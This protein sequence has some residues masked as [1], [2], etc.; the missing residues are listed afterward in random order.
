LDVAAMR[1][2]PA[3]LSV[4]LLGWGCGGDRATD[5]DAAFCREA[6]ERV[7]AFLGPEGDPLRGEWASRGPGGDG[8]GPLPDL[9]PERYGGTAVVGSTQELR[10][11]LNG[12]MGSHYRSVQHQLHLGLMTLVRRRGGDLE[13]EEYLARDWALA[14][15]GGAVTFHLRDDVR[16]HDGVPVTARDVA[17]TFDRL[18]DPAT[19]APLGDQWEGYRRGPDGVTVGDSLTLTFH[20]DPRSEPL[21]PWLD[22][23]IMPEHLLGEVPAEG[24]LGHPLGTRCPVG[25]GPFVFVEHRQDDRWVFR[26]NP[27]FPP[28]LGGRPFLDRYVYRVVPEQ[29]TLL[30]ELL[31]GGIDVF[32]RPVPEYAGA[33]EAEPGVRLLSS[34][35]RSVIYIAWNTRRP[36]LS[37]PRVRR[38]FTLGLDRVLYLQ[39]MRDGR[40]VLAGSGVPPFHWAYDPRL[41][42]LLRPDPERARA[43]LEEAGWSLPP[44]GEIRSDAEGNPLRITLL[45]DGRSVE[46]SDIALF[47]QAGLR[48]LGVEVRLQPLEFGTLLSRLESAQRDFDATVMSTLPPFRVDDR[49]LFHS[50]QRESAYGWAGLADPELDRLLD[51]LP[52]VVDRG[53]AR[54]LW[55]AYQRR[56]VE[57]QPYTYLFFPDWL[58]AVR[59]RLR[60]VEVDPRGEWAGVAGWWIPPEERR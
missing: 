48:A 8:S 2:G 22:T 13:P 32:I 19:G 31:T 46:Q 42:E 37:D 9:P 44:G 54:P 33:L 30:T 41:S 20:L 21:E 43:L 25:N 18:L 5:P 50:R 35:G 26:A 1:S 58:T 29:A 14:P 38:A 36:H 24:L 27:A 60:G 7:E 10:D 23:P 40:G 47:V 15:D 6:R 4:L 59:T 53:E 52:L 17:F 49:V 11:G 45:H 57:L 12:F 51:T 55:E 3:L 28:G 34:P 39:G 16:W 56:M